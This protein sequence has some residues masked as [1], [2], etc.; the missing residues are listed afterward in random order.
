MGRIAVRVS[1]KNVRY[2]LKNKSQKVIAGVVWPS[3]H[4]TFH[5]LIGKFPYC[6]ISDFTEKKN[7]PIMSNF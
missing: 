7:Q 6:I 5:I 3:L 1:V 2:A 4:G